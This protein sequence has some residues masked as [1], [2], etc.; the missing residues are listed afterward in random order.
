M[1]K[2]FALFLT[3][4]L[5]F[6]CLS[7]VLASPAHSIGTEEGELEPAVTNNENHWDY[8]SDG[9]WYQPI[10][11]HLYEN[12]DGSFT[13]VEYDGTGVIVEVYS[14]DYEI[15]S[16][17]TVA[18]D[19][20]T[21]IY[22][23]FFCGSEYN[24]LIFGQNNFND[25]DSVEVF[26][27]VKYT[28]DW[29]RVSQAGVFG[30]N[31]YTPF[32][33][34]TVNA[35]E[36][37]GYLLIHTCHEM[38]A[39]SDGLHH[40][41][42]FTLIV[43]IDEMDAADNSNAIRT[44][45]AGYCS[46]SFNQLI[47]LDGD[48]YITLDHG[49][50]YPR[51]AVLRHYPLTITDGEL[52][53]P[54]NDG[55]VVTIAYQ[56]VP[57]YSSNYTFTT[58]GGLQTTSYG[59]M[60]VGASS[61]STSF[62]DPKNVYITVTQRGNLTSEGHRLIWLTDYE[63][64]GT[65]NVG[66]PQLIK[67]NDNKL[68]VM[69]R[70]GA[71]VKMV[72]V[73]GE[74]NLISDVISSMRV[75]L[76]DCL[77]ILVGE[78]AVWY[79]TSNSAPVFYS[80]DVSGNA[81]SPE[82]PEDPA[83]AE[84][85]A[86]LN[87]EG[88]ELVFASNGSAF[89]TAQEYDGRY[90]AVSTAGT[91]EYCEFSTD[92]R[93]ETG[94][95]LMFDYM[96]TA[97]VSLLMVKNGST[98]F[99]TCGEPG[100]HRYVITADVPGLYSLTFKYMSASALCVMDDFRVVPMDGEMPPELYDALDDALNVEG[101]ELEFTTVFNY[102]FVTASTDDRLV[103]ISS[104]DPQSYY[105]LYST[106]VL[107][108]GDSIAFEYKLLPA[109]DCGSLTFSAG[110]SSQILCPHS[111][112]WQV[113]VF[114]AETAGSY[115]FQWQYKRGSYQG[116]RCMID[117]VRVIPAGEPLPAQEP[118]VNEEL[119]EALNVE[120]GEYD[121]YTVGTAPFTVKDEDGRYFAET[122]FPEGG[123]A[124]VSTFITF[125]AGDALF[126]DYKSSACSVYL[127]FDGNYKT[128]F[129]NTSGKWS[130]G[131]FTVNQAGTFKVDFSVSTTAANA[132]CAL[133]SVRIIPNAAAL[134]NEA[135]NVEGGALS[136]TCP[137]NSAPFYTEAESGR[138]MAKASAAARSVMS[139]TVSL[140]EGD[141]VFFEYR[142]TGITSYDYFY[143]GSGTLYSVYLYPGSGANWQQYSF[144]ATQTK[145]YTFMWIYDN[146]SGSGCLL[147]DNFRVVPAGEPDPDP[148][149]VPPTASFERAE[150]RERGEDDE[151]V[152]IRFLFK[153]DMNGSKVSFDPT[154]EDNF[155]YYNG[156]AND[157]LYEIIGITVDVTRTDSAVPITNTV[158]CRNIFAMH[159]AVEGEHTDGAWF[160]FSVVIYG[161]DSARADWLFTANAHVTYAQG[162]ET[163]AQSGTPVS[164]NGIINR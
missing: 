25:D 7:P 92:V 122:S 93:L 44:S 62:S 45:D 106:V 135:M 38:Y 137:S 60:T 77:P 105:R 161:V 121:F 139:V 123:T 102:T 153:V 17:R 64:G 91:S 2:T 1:R 5:A 152:G 124:T 48:S 107:A 47:T 33:A 63:H 3:V 19:A 29:V 140:N 131:A 42:N 111:N 115:S 58:L 79:V 66:N 88:S 81:P 144:T 65:A 118:V 164:L 125:N 70:E 132:Y 110:S 49:D 67:I 113:H 54:V 11:S 20:D 30:A 156:A 150:I 130:I 51:A 4:L 126:V 158:I 36:Y 8:W 146:S 9:K 59:Y 84:L 15:V 53:D 89:F 24:F 100:W 69:W 37:S 163:A 142:A 97:N 83:L 147:L 75:K 43:D 86:A 82:L 39:S 68:L 72:F 52:D 141:R 149:P 46:H 120:G 133:D 18:V 104:E 129:S 14:A 73:D 98:S 155:V 160:E 101:G 31:T 154:G 71:T 61:Q 90:A 159:E 35:A 50:Y 13:R 26:R 76:S 103:A 10:R 16:K 96:T 34:G 127:Y 22:G 94:D 143:F 87:A 128:A 85:N 116:S 41:S 157:D 21:P 57:N 40:Q 109:A 138:L 117:N 78:R 151:L 108:E 28:K 55:G 12:G 112:D 114:T 6:S 80:V 162:A 95:R 27:V 56:F 136:F 134:L 119:N 23:G 74:G 32:S 145:S 99:V 148:V